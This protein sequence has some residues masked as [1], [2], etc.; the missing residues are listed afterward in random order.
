[1]DVLYQQVVSILKLQK[2]TK[3]ALQRLSISLCKDLLLH[4]P[5]SYISKRVAPN[6][7]KL[8]QGERII[9]EVTIREIVLPKK[10]GSPTKIYADNETGG[11]V[12]VFFNKI[13]PWILRNLHVGLKKTI[14]GK[15]EW[16]DFY[17]QI[18]HPDF[19]LN[20]KQ[21]QDIE[22]VYPLTYGLNNKQLH[23]YI[24]KILDLL[25]I[26]HHTPEMTE[27]L[28]ALQ[29]INSPVELAKVDENMRKLAYYELL[30]NQLS[31]DYVR[32]I[33]S[34]PRGRAFAKASTLQQ[35]ILDNLGFMLSPGQ[36]SVMQEIEK[37]QSVATRMSRM[38]Q[39]DV[40]SGKTLVALM[41]MLNVA[42]IGT[43]STLMAPTD[44]LANQH[45]NFFKKALQN[46]NIDVAL[47]TGKTKAKER[48][49]ILD[50]VA[51]GKTLILVGTHALFQTQVMFHDLGFIIIDEQHKFGV[52]QRIKLLSK[53]TNPDLLVMTAT[54]IPRSLTMTLFGD[55]SV[56][57]LISKPTNRPDII[58][59]L[60]SSSKTQ[61]V[62]SSLGRKIESCEKVYWVC[63]QVEQ[64]EESKARDVVTRFN[65][66]DVIFPG[67]V[68][69]IHGKLP[70]DVKDEMMQKFKNGGVQILVATT[71]I[72]VGIDV[73]DATL[74]V[75]ENAE[76]FGLAQIHQL[77]GRVGRGDLQSHCILLYEYLA[78]IVKTR[79]EIMRRSNDGFYIAE[80][81]LLLRGGGEVLGV[82]QSGQIEFRFADLA[83][84]MD[85]LMQCNK[86]AKD[87][88]YDKYQWLIRFFNNDFVE[89][90]HMA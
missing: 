34:L 49:E 89:G 43:Q 45:F 10:R 29:Y 62:I 46:T 63:P 67:K 86:I 50:N 77:R 3:D 76:K 24:L 69:L 75:I 51:S 13:S 81:D 83:R 7:S 14:E 28:L 56:S 31:L 11:I 48:K 1:M 61:E 6:L 57:R 8:K 85:L 60:K 73:P 64:D 41:T 40:G 52:E 17:Y 54:P 20:N 87:G 44:L 79:L 25:S 30:S 18:S 53:A 47:L 68:G 70:P 21:A 37:D 80:Q 35:R 66:L 26:G 33:A 74:I 59:I 90:K 71:V 9:A 12:L 84:D 4:K 38:L 78:G 19:I 36:V 15:V 65:S 72:E 58:T 23:S 39:G 88:D 55:M 2:H 5:T 82:K 42:E 16:N 32:R 27:F 22:P